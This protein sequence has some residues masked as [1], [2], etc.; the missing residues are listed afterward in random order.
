MKDLNTLFF[1]AIFFN[2]FRISNSEMGGKLFL[3]FTLEFKILFGI[4]ASIN[5]SKDS[6][7]NFESISEY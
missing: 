1:F 2:L 5:S 7:P 6:I 3:D 4:T